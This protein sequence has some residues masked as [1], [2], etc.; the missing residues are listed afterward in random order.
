VWALSGDGM[1]NNLVGD[2]TRPSTITS[3]GVAVRDQL[4]DFP[5]IVL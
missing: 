5:R 3:V 2:I 1:G 4:K